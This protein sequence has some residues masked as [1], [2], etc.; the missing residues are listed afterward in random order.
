MTDYTP[1]PIDKAIHEAQQLAVRHA[2]LDGEAR[3]LEK[4]E[5]ILFSELVNQS[6]ESSV[7]KAEHWARNHDR[8]RKHVEEMVDA[9]TQANIAKAQ[10]D[11][12]QMKFEAWRTQ[13]ATRRAEMN[14]R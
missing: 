6:N 4:L 7:A 14:I 10:W 12:K 1:D 3:R 8:Y 5:K 13:Q 11:A 2:E 9:R